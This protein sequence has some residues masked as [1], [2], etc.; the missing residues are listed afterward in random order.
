MFT[1]DD[2]WAIMFSNSCYCGLDSQDEEDDDEEDEDD[3]DDDYYRYHDHDDLDDDELSDPNHSDGLSIGSPSESSEYHVRQNFLQELMG[4]ELA[5]RNE[6]DEGQGEWIHPRWESPRFESNAVD[7][8]EQELISL[9]RPRAMVIALIRRGATKQ[10]IR[11]YTLTYDHESGI[12]VNG[13]QAN[14][15]LGWNISRN[16]SDMDG[17]IFMKAV[18][19]ETRDHPRRFTIQHLPRGKPWIIRLVPKMETLDDLEGS[20]DSWTTEQSLGRAR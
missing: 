3:H 7:V 5:M 15:H 6:H 8:T 4:W 14:I 20:D 2:P 19:D 1:A 18:M 11:K 13:P 16:S 17:S 9:S 10:M 12:V